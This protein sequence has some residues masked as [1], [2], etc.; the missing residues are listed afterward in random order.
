L[1]AG[2]EIS[3]KI[4]SK[5]FYCMWVIGIF[6]IDLSSLDNFVCLSIK[7]RNIK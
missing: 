7:A 6:V 2:T 3:D 1:L 4:T 5:R